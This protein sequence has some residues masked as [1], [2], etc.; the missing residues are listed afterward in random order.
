MTKAKDNAKSFYL[1]FIQLLQ[2]QKESDK[3][4]FKETL[5]DFLNDIKK[6]GEYIKNNEGKPKKILNN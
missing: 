5:D 6:M 3:I 1:K 2:C 4:A